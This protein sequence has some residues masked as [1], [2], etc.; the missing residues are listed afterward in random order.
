MSQAYF[1]IRELF[2]FK[3][4]R[5]RAEYRLAT[6]KEA[7]AFDPTRAPKYWEDPA[8]ASSPRRVVVYDYVFYPAS[9]PMLDVLLLKREDAATV[10]IF[11]PGIDVPAP[12]EAEIPNPIRELKPTEKVVFDALGNP[13]VH[14]TTLDAPQGGGF[15]AADRAM[16]KSIAVKLGI[17]A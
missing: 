4:Y 10:N 13:M 8:A 17:A 7:P 5:T 9:K 12:R 1:P 15:T 14:D 3:N 11:E 2:V 16:L 6:G